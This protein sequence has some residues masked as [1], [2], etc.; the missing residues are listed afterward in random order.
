MLNTILKTSLVMSL[1][2]FAV[3]TSSMSQTEPA[4]KPATK[5]EAVPAV[6]EVPHTQE[7]HAVVAT[8]EHPKK[9]AVAKT[10]KKPHKS[11]KRHTEDDKIT[12]ELNMAHKGAIMPAHYDSK[13]QDH[14]KHD[15]MEP[16]THTKAVS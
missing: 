5:P 10:E 14:Q 1:L 8:A 4:T 6:P 15:H 7:Q 12:K 11:H 2:V 9:E 3:T 16:K 13:A